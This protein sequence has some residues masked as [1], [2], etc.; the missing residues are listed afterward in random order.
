MSDEYRKVNINTSD[1]TMWKPEKEND[2]LEGVYVDKKTN[3][4]ANNSNVYT[5][6]KEDGTFVAF[7][8]STVI[9]TNFMKI[10]LGA[11][12]KLVY[13]GQSKNEK[14]QRTFKNFDI[15][16]KQIKAPESTN[17]SESEDINP[18]EIPF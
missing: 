14:T 2:E 6:Q 5:V 18:D 13:L 11:Q 12:V 15:F 4:G 16:S 8:G 1:S 17:T 7:W 9:D 3:V 10:P